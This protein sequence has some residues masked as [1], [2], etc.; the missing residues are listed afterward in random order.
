LMEA[1]QWWIVTHQLDHFEK[2]TKVKQL[3]ESE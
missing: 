1:A 3:V 2:A